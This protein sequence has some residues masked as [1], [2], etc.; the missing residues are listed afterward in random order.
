[1]DIFYYENSNIFTKYDRFRVRKKRLFSMSLNWI[2][3]AIQNTDMIH[4]HIR[5]LNENKRRRF[6]RYDKLH[7]D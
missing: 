1:M 6:K 3:N 4:V 5:K 2:T 7:C